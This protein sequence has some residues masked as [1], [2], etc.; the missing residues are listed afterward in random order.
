MKNAFNFSIHPKG[1]SIIT[2][3]PH[4]A[5]HST[6][7]QA[8]SVTNRTSWCGESLAE[9]QS[10]SGAQQ[11]KDRGCRREVMR[12]RPDVVSGKGEPQQDEITRDSMVQTLFCRKQ[13]KQIEK[14]K[15]KKKTGR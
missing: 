10:D 14:Q 1:F 6:M 12:A 4:P 5:K 2:F 15:K 11:T 9:D 3:K 8:A 7:E 13:R